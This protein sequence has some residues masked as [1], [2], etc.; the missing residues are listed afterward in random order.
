[1]LKKTYDISPPVVTVLL[2]LLLLFFARCT[3]DSSNTSRFYHPDY[4]T[5]VFDKVRATDYANKESAFWWMDSIFK[6]YPNPGLLDEDGRL[7]IKMYFYKDEVK[8][9]PKALLYVDSILVMLRPHIDHKIICENYVQ[10][11][12]VKGDIY[13]NAKDYSTGF[14]YYQQGKNLY[15][16]KISD[17]TYP[18]SYLNR[19]GMV[20]F[21]QQKFN[22]AKEL[23]QE[24]YSYAL[25][26]ENDS[27]GRLN[28]LQSTMVW[29]ANCYLNLKMP[30]SSTYY[31]NRV[32]AMI[33]EM[34]DKYPTKKADIA[35]GKANIFR[36]Q[37]MI[38]D[39]RKQYSAAEE[40]F[41]K[42]IQESPHAFYKL[43]T[44][45]FL[46]KMYIDNN[47]YAK[48]DAL[49]DIIKKSI[50][51]L[52]DGWQ[53]ANWY[54]LKSLLYSK[55]GNDK[56]AYKLLNLYNV[57]TDSLTKIDKAFQ[58]FNIGYE[59]RNHEQ[60]MRYEALK[61]RSDLQ[62]VYLIA[63]A[64]FSILVLVIVSLIWFN[65]KRSSRLKREVEKKNLDLEKSFHALEQSHQENT[66]L[67][68]VVA[69]DL[70]NP[71]SAVQNLVYSLI[72]R[73]QEDESK[74][75]L[76]LIKSA[77][78][79]CI[80]LVKE[81][82][83]NKKSVSIQKEDVD[84]GELLY[85][86]VNLLQTKA[87]EKNQRILLTSQNVYVKLN[88]QKIWR[89]MSNII[90]NAIKFSPENAD[91][92]VFLVKKNKD[93]LLSVEDQ[94]IG[95]SEE[96]KETIFSSFGSIGNQGTNGEESHGLGLAICKKIIDEHGG[97][98]WF[99][100][101]VGKGSVFYIELPT[102]QEVE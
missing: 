33:T 56:Q 46:A 48:A 85:Q 53:L 12:L 72:K 29:I 59:T 34:E 22:L 57:Y 82:L 26:S 89:V 76:T 10:M 67:M 15:T 32:S 18:G 77:C 78:T 43:S 62:Y 52:S 96:K 70:K 1:M 21:Q 88:R 102:G 35:Y 13:F 39:Q 54:R 28:E 8:D 40:F 31:F 73:T 86:C 14:R 64:V 90:T 23:F 98:I 4:F 50:D 93:I 79:S 51:S 9:F 36:G 45:T 87:Q 30:D 101:Y 37:A 5:P 7:N 27:F 24:N 97:Q 11:L 75:M 99:N 16:E 69:H 49:M 25:T 81:L 38:Q 65:L 19:L 20:Y 74:E 55:Q 60:E 17:S 80:T 2:F 6:Q 83:N 61:K 66:T 100:S 68:Q 63:T 47:S 42:S 58:E 71:I 94:G 41:L 95:I 91:I 44:Q 3:G 84:I 92:Q